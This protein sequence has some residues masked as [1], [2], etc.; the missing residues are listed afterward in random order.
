MRQEKQ[1][2]TI[3]CFVDPKEKIRCIN[4]KSFKHNIYIGILFGLSAKI[5]IPKAILCKLARYIMVPYNWNDNFKELIL[6]CG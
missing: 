1:H 2:R 4:C 6:K 5:C 3:G